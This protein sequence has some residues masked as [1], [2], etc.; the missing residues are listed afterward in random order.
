MEIGGEALKIIIDVI[1]FPVDILR[2][3]ERDIHVNVVSS[4]EV[5]N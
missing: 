4:G 3:L 2:P 5:L 1:D